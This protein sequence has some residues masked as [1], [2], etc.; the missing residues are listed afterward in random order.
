MT[1]S[2][3]LRYCAT[4]LDHGLDALTFTIPAGKKGPPIPGELLSQNAA[5][6]R[7]YRIQTVAMLRYV[8]RQIRNGVKA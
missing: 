1:L 8:E 7:N 3:I 2:E 5:G 6:D 4:G